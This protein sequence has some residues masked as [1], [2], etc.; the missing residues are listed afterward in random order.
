M[1]HNQQICFTNFAKECER[2]L[3]QAS[4]IDY[5]ERIDRKEKKG[6]LTVIAQPQHLKMSVEAYLAL[7]RESQE[8]RYEYIDG[9]AYLLAGGTPVHA[10]IAANLIAEINA[11]LKGGACRVYTS[12]AKVRLSTGRY[13]FP[14]ITVSCDERDHEPDTEA[15]H[16]PRL[17]IEILSPSTEAYD[18]GNKSGYYRSCP[19]I[20][21]YVLVSTQKANVE[22]YRRATGKL[23]TLYPFGQGEL[24]ELASIG[25][26]LPIASIYEHI[27]LLE[28]PEDRNTAK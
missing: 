2:L 7:D 4:T 23:W 6:K 22:V 16:Y 20:Q 14:D 12:D 18:R 1:K 15:L 10:L 13:V 19:T 21:E 5:T 3:A 26:A 9:Y 27:R 11:Q 24:V 28:E 25:V 8:V 17:V